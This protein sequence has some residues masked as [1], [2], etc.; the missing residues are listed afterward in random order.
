M[1]FEPVLTTLEEQGRLLYRQC[2]IDNRSLPGNFVGPRSQHLVRTENCIDIYQWY[3][4]HS[5]TSA[6][7]DS[8]EATD[9]STQALIR[10]TVLHPE[11]AYSI[12]LGL[13]RL[14]AFAIPY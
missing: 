3:D 8:G 12:A 10:S 9:P 13:G 2:K 6:Q 11:R 14:Q 5:E 7:S 1:I 4:H